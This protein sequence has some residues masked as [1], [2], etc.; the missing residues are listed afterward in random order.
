MS[1]LSLLAEM[2]FRIKQAQEAVKDLYED[3]MASKIY[4]VTFPD[5]FNDSRTIEQIL[6]RLVLTYLA[7]KE[8]GVM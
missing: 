1:K 2:I 4:N 3:Q 8:T 7:A 6:I 5:W